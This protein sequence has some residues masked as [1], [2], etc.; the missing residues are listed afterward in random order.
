MLHAAIKLGWIDEHYE[1]G[2]FGLRAYLRDNERTRRTTRRYLSAGTDVRAPS[3][4]PVVFDCDDL[5]SWDAHETM[6]L[7]PICKVNY[8]VT[9]N[10]GLTYWF[11]RKNLQSWC[12]IDSAI[13]A[14][15]QSFEHP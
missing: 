9:P 14:L 12:E 5:F 8:V 7:Q 2:P 1:A 10:V 4:D 13:R 15:I 3:G 11:Y 6:D